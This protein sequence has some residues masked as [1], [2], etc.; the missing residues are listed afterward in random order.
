MK[1]EVNPAIIA[2]VIVIGVAAIGFFAFKM[3]ST[4]EAAPSRPSG[5]DNTML[6]SQRGQTS[7]V[8]QSQQNQQDSGTPRP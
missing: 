7:N 2:T 8:L 4:P 1:K 6:H 3:M 5:A